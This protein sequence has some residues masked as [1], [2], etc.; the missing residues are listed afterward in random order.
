VSIIIC[1]TQKLI[2]ESGYGNSTILLRIH[3]S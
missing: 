2:R 3:M 1:Q